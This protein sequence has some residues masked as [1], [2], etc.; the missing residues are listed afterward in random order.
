M[1][2]IVIELRQDALD[3]AVQI[4]DLL[5]KAL[6][7]ASK[8]RIVE[9][10]KWTENELSGYKDIRE[11]PGYRRI[12]GSVSGKD[13]YGNWQQIKLPDSESENLLSNRPCDQPIAEIESL[14]HDS[15]SSFWHMPFSPEV[16]QIFFRDMPFYSQIALLVPRINL[17]RIVDAVRT[18][19]LNW[20]LKLEEDGIV[21]EGLSFTNQE[22]ETAEKS[23]YNINNF[24][25][26]VH[27]SQIQQQTS[28]SSQVIN[29]LDNNLLREFVDDIL[30]QIDELDLGKT[31]KE[32]LTAEINTIKAQ[33]ES[34]HPKQLILKEC[35]D[36]IRGI[37]V[38]AGGG[39]AAQLLTHYL[40]NLPK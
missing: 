13:P 9:F 28:D 7:V 12:G 31:S 5:R 39:V 29:K 19:I 10:K 20:S 32:E 25:A 33:T 36:S 40:L 30:K 3:G 4:S 16:Q 27:S 23:S 1:S 34:P 2:S 22:R 21:G 37:L 14:L 24:Y 8:L 17:V 6:T 38:G 11:A 35:L 15:T 18:T 26:E